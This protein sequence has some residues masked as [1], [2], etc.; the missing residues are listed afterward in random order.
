MAASAW[1]SNQRNVT[2]FCIGS[3]LAWGYVCRRREHVVEAVVARRDALFHAGL[4]H[5]FARLARLVAHGL[6]EGR[7]SALLHENEC[8]EGLAG[9]PCVVELLG[10]DE[11]LGG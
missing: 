2:I 11:P 4:D 9:V 3:S 1:P 5:R 10:A 8:V 7:A 6:G